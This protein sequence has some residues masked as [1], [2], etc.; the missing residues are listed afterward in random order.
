MTDKKN[1]FSHR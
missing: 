1:N